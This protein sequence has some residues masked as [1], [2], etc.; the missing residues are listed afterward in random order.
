M[1]TLRLPARMV[2]R[3]RSAL[4]REDEKERFAFLYAGDQ[5]DLLGSSVLP[6]D[7]TDMGRQSRTACR[8]EPSLERDHITSCYEQN[9]A[10][11]LV[12]SH[13]FSEDPNFSSID[14]ESIGKFRKWINGLFPD[15]SFGFA[16]IGTNGIEAIGDGDGCMEA[17]SV[18]VIGD[19]KLDESVPG[20]ESRFAP[21][22]DREQ[23]NPGQ[24]RFDRGVRALGEKG[25]KRL[26]D[27][28]VGIV[29]V[30]GVGSI[31]AE[32]IARLG[33]EEIVLIDPDTVEPSNLQRLVGAYDHHVSK[34]KVTA[35]REHLW[36]SGSDGVEV[37][38]VQAPVQEREDVLDSCDVIVGCVDSVSARSFCN[39]Y[40]VK[41]LKYYLDVG[42][43]IDVGSEEQIEKKGYVQL[44][45]PGSNGC[46][47]CLGRHD[48]E[49]THIERLSHKELEEEQERGYIDDE[50]LEPEP[51]VIH[52]NGICASKAVSVLVDLVT[53][54]RPPD[55]VRYEDHDHEMT[56]LTTKP[57]ESCPTCGDEGVLGV[58][59]RSFGDA[60]FIP[61]EQPLASD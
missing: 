52:L 23:E 29:G 19:W 61:E 39:E 51:A 33:V 8:P 55:F 40:A 47:D 10:P 31:V 9:L 49:A 32:Q 59:R 34:P 18:E 7:D 20:A 15:R 16:V 11:V 1:R 36:K 45:A 5:G 48:Q 3:L 41:H 57:S 58:G 54:S 22:E 21:S 25:Q 42:V 37:E 12:H 53:G 2:R 60:E 50:D 14:V 6:V 35:V 38:A 56:E 44:V 17:L 43:R 24:E 13:P 4:I 27:T 30:G 26:Q 46:F 28:T